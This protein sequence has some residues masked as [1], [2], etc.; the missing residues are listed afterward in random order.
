MSSQVIGVTMV[1]NEADIIGASLAHMLGQVDAVVVIDNGST[2]G[3]T[4]ILQNAMADLGPDRMTI[5]NTFER[6]YLQSRRMTCAAMVAHRDHGAR[7]IVPFDA[8]EFWRPPADSATVADRLR[9]LDTL[10]GGVVEVPILNHYAT[11]LDPAW[12]RRAKWRPQ[13]MPWRTRTPLPL[14]KVAFRWVEGAVIEM[15]NHGVTL[16]GEEQPAP[17]DAGITIRHFPYR[18]AEQ[19]TRKAIQGAEAYRAA[20]D[21]VPAD[22]GAHW[23]AWG[24]LMDVYGEGIMGDIFREHYWFLS[25]TDAGLIHDPIA[26]GEV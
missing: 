22:A 14:H 1:R 8:D 16:P 2:D 25:P 4:D 10:P 15:G 12:G 20:G 18:S 23:R 17:F 21:D 6:A 5:L 24:R 26:L 3:T 7:W 11:A 13:C 9:S 19:M